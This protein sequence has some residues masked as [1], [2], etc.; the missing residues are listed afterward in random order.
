MKQ[1]NKLKIGD[2]VKVIDGDQEGEK[3]RIEYLAENGVEASIVTDAGWHWWMIEDNLKKI[4][5]NKLPKKNLLTN[6]TKE[7]MEKYKK[8]IIVI[9]PTNKRQKKECEHGYKAACP[10]CSP[11]SEIDIPHLRKVERD[12][13]SQSYNKDWSLYVY[14]WTPAIMIFLSLLAIIGYA[15]TK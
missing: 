14:D 15:L 3:G 10:A 2:R 6:A 13:P 1:T 8:E 7:T 5:T 12:Y 9:P 4:P 11:L